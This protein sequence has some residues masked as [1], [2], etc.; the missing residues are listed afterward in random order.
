MDNY[1]GNQD[2]LVPTYT[3]ELVSMTQASQERIITN[4]ANP[5]ATIAQATL[6]TPGASTGVVGAFTIVAFET[7]S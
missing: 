7:T 4:I 5:F 6:T 2:I 1:T 3:Q